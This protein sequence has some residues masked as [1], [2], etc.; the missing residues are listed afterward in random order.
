MCCLEGGPLLQISFDGQRTLEMQPGWHV[1]IHRARYALPALSLGCAACDWYG[2]IFAGFSKRAQKPA[3][4][5]WM[6][7]L[8]GY[9][10]EWVWEAVLKKCWRSLGVGRG[11]GTVHVY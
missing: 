5:H 10:S 8:W 11:K 6:L 3:T 4:S 7:L 9:N 1:R 2:P